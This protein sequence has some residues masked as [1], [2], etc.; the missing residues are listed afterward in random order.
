MIKDGKISNWGNYP[1]RKSKIGEFDYVD[2]IKQF[3][4]DHNKLIV[5]GN[6]RCYGDSSLN[7][8]VLSQLAYD[9][10]IELN[11]K[12]A[13][14]TCQSGVLLSDILDV[15]VKY[16]LFLPVTPGTKF[17]TVG[18]AVA[19]DVHGKNHHVEGCFSDHVLWMTVLLEDGSVAKCSKDDNPE[20]F[21]ATSGGMGLTGVILEVCFRLKP[22]NSAYIRQESIKAKN[23]DEVMKLFEDS[24]NWTYTVAWINCLAKGKSQGRS[25]LMRGEHADVDELPKKC[26][27]RPLEL[28]KKLQLNIPLNFPNFTLNKWSIK[29]FNFLFYNKQFKKVLKNIIDYNSFFYPLDAIANW[30]R[31]YGSR[32]FTQYQFVLPKENSSEGLKEILTR[33]S[34]SGKGSFLAVLKLFGKPNDNAMLSFPREGYTLALDF[35]IEKGLFK[36]LDELDEIVIKYG[37]RHYLAK[38]VRMTANTFSES[39]LDKIEQFENVVNKF[40]KGKFESIQTKRLKING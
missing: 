29:A 34:K 1:V 35:R 19:A 33:I 10:I 17:I 5:R 28:K 9:K 30:N 20:L 38:D 40:N 3:V 13:I 16:G 37:G 6:G 12:E 36:L 31:M 4:S 8:I 18:G 39:Y 15:T 24:E 26:K 14:I 25:I 7:D 21:Y 11:R 23:L 2:D 32:G 22:I 27:N